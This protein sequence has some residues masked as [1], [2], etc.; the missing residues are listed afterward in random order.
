ML[1]KVIA[2]MKELLRIR[3]KEPARR[4]PDIQQEDTQVQTKLSKV[5]FTSIS[6]GNLP[7]FHSQLSVL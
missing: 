2:S 1:T 4:Q 7:V 5:S 3:N 6:V